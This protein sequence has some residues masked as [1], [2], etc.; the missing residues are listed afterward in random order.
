MSI[1]D[2]LEEN[3]GVARGFDFMR[4][5]LALSIVAVHSCWVVSNSTTIGL[6]RGTWFPLYALVPAFF[7]VSGF[8]VTG[9]AQ[10]LTLPNFLLNRSLRVFPALAVEI[11]AGAL[12]LG[13]IFT[14]L[15]LSTYFSSPQTWRYLTNIVGLVNYR[16]PGVFLDLPSAGYVNLSLWTI[17]ME[18][19]CY[20]V[21]AMMVVTG[22][23]RR[24]AAVLA[25]TLLWA[26]CGVGVEL[27]HLAKG[28][29]LVAE[30]L[31]EAFFGRSPRLALF[32]LAGI[33]AFQFRHRIPYSKLLL[34]LS[35]AACAAIY[36]FAPMNTEAPII[37]ALGCVPVVYVTLYAGVSNLPR[38][39]FFHRG[40][41]SYGIYL[42]GFP[43]QQAVKAAL[44]GLTQPWALDAVAIPLVVLFAAFSWHVIERP[45]LKVRRKFSF[46]A[47]TRLREA[48]PPPR[49][50]ASFP[51]GAEVVA[52]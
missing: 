17:P 4:V 10:R 51:D 11:V 46:V 1:G 6:T 8:L 39:P 45:V 25:A 44:P 7:T 18:M 2:K 35:L 24:P 47:R 32:C 34:T 37:A 23:M 16:L 42:Y 27:L 14:V 31:K 30:V 15:P 3:G 49:A 40:D 36:A 52:E 33:T 43:L 28:H 19:A 22:I 48:P 21:I 13:P 5:A 50:R 38:L 41:Y 26:G 29:T 12:I 20:G 9:S